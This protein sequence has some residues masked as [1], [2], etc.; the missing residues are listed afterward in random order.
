MSN[1]KIKIAIISAVAVAA[2]AMAFVQQQT[3]KELRQDNE[4]L[5]RQAAE[6][7]PLREQVAR[8]TQEAANA[9]GGAPAREEQARELARLRN[10]V[11][12]LRRQTNELAAARQEIQTLHQRAAAE[13]ET[14][15]GAVA[16]LQAEIRKTQS[17]NACVNN[18]RLI[19]A[20][21]HIRVRLR[22]S[23]QSA[24]GFVLCSTQQQCVFVLDQPNH[25][26]SFGN[27]QRLS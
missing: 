23:P 25:L 26:L 20:A 2:L 8:A 19:D 1:I 17:L 27:F 13:T 12:Q 22:F 3:I 24:R 15:R 6:V 16:S 14:R 4:A 7:P 9:G 21:K 10:E 5:T 11:S 18:L